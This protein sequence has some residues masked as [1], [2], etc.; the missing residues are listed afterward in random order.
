MIFFFF[1]KLHSA[2]FF[3]VRETAIIQNKQ[4]FASFL[5][6]VKL[7]AM[8]FSI[9]FYPISRDSNLMRAVIINK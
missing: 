4:K 8:R 2:E 5:S 9:H 1:S 3:K 7:F 6:Q